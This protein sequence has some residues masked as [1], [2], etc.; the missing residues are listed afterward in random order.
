MIFEAMVRLRGEIP[1]QVGHGGLRR[2]RT[3]EICFR[4]ASAHQTCQCKQTR[5]GVTPEENLTSLKKAKL[6]SATREEPDTGPDVCQG[7]GSCSNEIPWTWHQGQLKEWV[8]FLVS[9]SL[10]LSSVHV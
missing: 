2:A 8:G 10:T 5:E 6:E 1:D 7:R 3:V 4:D 9:S